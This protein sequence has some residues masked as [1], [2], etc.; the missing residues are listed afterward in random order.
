VPVRRFAAPLHSIQG[1]MIAWLF[2]PDARVKAE[3]HEIGGGGGAP[4]KA[5]PHGDNAARCSKKFLEMDGVAV[6]ICPARMLF[7]FDA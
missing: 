4:S 3:G 5:W 1:W 7:A 6:C 2:L